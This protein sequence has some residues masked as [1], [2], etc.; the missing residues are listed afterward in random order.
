MNFTRHIHTKSRAQ[1]MVEFAIA[2]P[3]LLMLLYGLLE[4]GR[5]L[6]MYSTVVTASRQA[7]RYG[8][9]TGLGNNSVP[10]YQDCVGIR[11]AA[12]AVGFLGPFDSINLYYDSGTGENLYCT[13]TIGSGLTP[14]LLEGNRTRL[15]VTVQEEFYPI[16][17]NLVP[18][19]QRTIIAT[20][21]RTILYS[22][23]IIVESAGEEWGG[24][25]GSGALTLS[26]TTTPTTYTTA[27]EVINFSYLVTNS[28]TGDIITPITI[29]DSKAT[30][31]CS[32]QP[33][34]LVA[35]ASF[36]CTGFY[37]TAQADVDAGS[38]TF[39]VTATASGTSS[40]Q[41]NSTV[42]A[43]RFPALTL[44]KSASPTATSVVGTVITYTY[45]L[46]N[47]G[48]VTLTSPYTVNDDKI[49]SVSCPSTGSLAP[50]AVTTCTATYS[51][52]QPDINARSIVNV[53]TA[54]A[55]FGSQTVTSNQATAIV[56]T[57]ALFLSV[58]YSPTSVNQPNQVITYTYRIQNLSDGTLTS[59]Y[60]VSDNRVT[61]ENCT[62]AVSPLG[63]GASTTCTGSYT[64]TQVD[65][66]A[67]AT[68]VNNVVATARDG[69]NNQTR[70]S[71]EVSVSVV[72][73]RNPALSMQMVASPA[74]ATNLNDLVTYTYALANSGNVTL[75][76]PFTV[77]DDKASNITCNPTTS[78]A[79]GA[80][81]TCAGTRTVSQADLDAGFIT[82]LATASA[83]FAG[84]T[85]SSSQQS[86]T[87]TTYVGPRLVLQITP[88]SST[89]FG[90][91][92]TIIY[93]Y[94]LVNTGNVPLSGPYAI[95][96]NI[97][98]IE[99]CTSNAL[100]AGASAMCTGWYKT[101]QADVNAGSV[102]N[103]ASATATDG[104]QTITSNVA[105]ATVTVSP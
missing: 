67:G 45:T 39:Q 36:V 83:T 68:L 37:Q 95:V 44:A 57:P 20:S 10:R 81:M 55:R 66:D 47:S 3:I 58:T 80:T 18:F 5:L 86:T 1:A 15:V 104:I 103:Q 69:Q 79:P 88:N 32:G 99:S 29:N 89:V 26:I 87:V 40:P 84:Q 53:A 82:N 62:G 4:A 70:T 49:G 11:G 41:V 63:P 93:T 54:T 91:D 43:T 78:L 14:A 33:A 46:T 85:V 100:P 9:A 31:S 16:V 94:T 21:R 38:I 35:G 74:T 101:T 97:G 13:G 102:T 50:G 42:T 77:V 52:K 61:N 19:I 76:P 34:L 105:T 59:P 12:N 7:V 30:T 75:S 51:V 8:A 65:L 96:G 92:Q 27:G 25:G 73:A 71:N 17:P 28:G 22:V 56:Y 72:L 90:I 23:P 48:N 24:T 60:V 98:N 64:V 6:F 2:L